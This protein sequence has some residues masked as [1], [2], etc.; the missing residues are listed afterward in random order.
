MDEKIL[1][2]LVSVA[3]GWILA[4]GTALAKNWWAARNLTGGLITELEDIYKQLDRV[5]LITH[6][7]MQICANE[8]IGTGASLPIHNTFFRQYFKEAF[9]HLNR[10]QR[11]SYQLIHSTLDALNKRNEALEKILDDFHKEYAS[12][13]DEERILVAVAIVRDRLIAAYKTAMVTRWHIKHHLN[14][15]KSPTYDYKG[16]VHESYVKFEQELDDDVKLILEKAKDIK[17]EDLEKIYDPKMFTQQGHS[18]SL[19]PL[20]T[21]SPSAQRLPNPNPAVFAVVR[22]QRPRCVQLAA[23]N[24]Q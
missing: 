3:V 10:E 22:P 17:R 16:P 8:G 4:Q 6:R 2:A 11:I 20:C 21:S 1:I 19:D 9:S 15:P 7:E 24:L 13:P 23:Q 5:V 12:S 18:H 14:N